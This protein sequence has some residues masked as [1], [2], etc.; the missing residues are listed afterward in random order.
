ML[1]ALTACANPQSEPAKMSAENPARI[2]MRRLLAS[3]TVAVSIEPVDV[4][5]N[6]GHR[7]RHVRRTVTAPT[8]TVDVTVDRNA[9]TRIVRITR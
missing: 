5:S 2:L 9:C 8:C 4:P 1:G 3:D 6:Y 7:T